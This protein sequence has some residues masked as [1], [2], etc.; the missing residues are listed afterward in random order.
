MSHA[1]VCITKEL[2]NSKSTMSRGNE[3]SKSASCKP[4]VKTGSGK[5]NWARREESPA[6]F[7]V[8]A[9]LEHRVVYYIGPQMEPAA[10]R[11]RAWPT[12]PTRQPT[13]HSV[14]QEA[15]RTVEHSDV[16]SEHELVPGRQRPDCAAEAQ[17][18]ATRCACERAGFP[19]LPRHGVLVLLQQG[20]DTHI[21]L[22]FSP[23]LHPKRTLFYSIRFPGPVS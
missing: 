4:N 15:T 17:S 6:D 13:L 7:C 5:K 19:P 23:S 21:F 14:M 11:C 22:D 1:T 18:S 16:T 12:S 10:V 9:H 8:E 20:L 3:C 2:T